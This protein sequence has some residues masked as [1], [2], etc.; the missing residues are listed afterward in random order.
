MKWIISSAVLMVV[1]GLILLRGGGDSPN[2]SP[3]PAPFSDMASKTFA[4]IE[5]A[6]RTLQGEK[7][8]KLRTGELKS[9]SEAK[10]W[11]QVNYTT[12]FKEAWTTLLNAE[13][14]SF[15]GENWTAEKEAAVA[16]RYVR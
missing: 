8:V 9:E 15:G 13:Y 14:E 7:A 3:T 16:E 12:K 6:W 10:D 5:A 11:F 2:P 1:G 4:D